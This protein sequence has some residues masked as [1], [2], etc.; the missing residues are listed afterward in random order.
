MKLKN[1]L[2]HM[3]ASYKRYENRI[4]NPVKF[5]LRCASV[6]ISM[7]YGI[8]EEHGDQELINLNHELNEILDDAI[9]WLEEQGSPCTEI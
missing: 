7:L 4:K 6:H 5:A 9:D 2:K 3:G 8:L 1:G